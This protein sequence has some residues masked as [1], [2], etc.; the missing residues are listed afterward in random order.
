MLPVVAPVVAVVV[1]VVVVATQARAYCSNTVSSSSA[2][3]RIPV[4]TI[5]IPFVILHLP[6]FYPVVSFPALLAY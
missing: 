1:V 4:M 2:H 5:S 3:F 6:C